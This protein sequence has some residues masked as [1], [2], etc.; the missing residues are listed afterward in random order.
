MARPP[1]AYAGRRRRQAAKGAAGTSR[2]MVPIDVVRRC[3]R[4]KWETAGQWPDME[5]DAD[6]GL[7]D[8]AKREIKRLGLDFHRESI[9]VGSSVGW[10][11]LTIWGHGGMILREL[12]GSKGHVYRAQLER[13]ESL[14][15]AG[16]DAVLW[17]PE[18][19]WDGTI[20]AE[21]DALTRPRA[22]VAALSPLA[23]EL[24]A[25]GALMLDAPPL[26]DGIRE[27]LHAPTGRRPGDS[28]WT[29]GQR[30]CGCPMEGEH[31]DMCS[32]YG[33]AA[34]GDRRRK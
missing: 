9:S 23:P 27:I 3:L 4:P 1:G 7:L 33:R 29:P 16:L 10:P 30:A 5:E 12:K 15:A 25:L 34:A 26:P 18:D 19:W 11:D 20:T 2:A 28:V 21:L 24:T 32:R 13:I 22:E 14:R 17:W 31:L 8:L 6:G